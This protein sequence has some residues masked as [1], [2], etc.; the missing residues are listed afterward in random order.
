MKLKMLSLAALLAVFSILAVG[1]GNP[2]DE[3]IE[4]EL[5]AIF[6]EAMKELDNE[7]TLPENA[8]TKVEL[9]KTFEAEGFANT[10][11][12]Y[13]DN[14]G[15]P[16]DVYGFETAD[17]G[18]KFIALNVTV[19]NSG[20]EEAQASQLNYTLDFGGEENAEHSYYGT[21]APNIEHF[22]STDLGPGESYTGDFLFEVPAE[23]GPLN[24][25]LVFNSDP[26]DFKT[27]YQ[28]IL[29]PLQ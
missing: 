17:E 7:V 9:G 26:F 8:N 4:K 12:F 20:T 21:T 27:D 25:T 11:N 13:L 1:C 18:N 16:E 15:N 24:W 22:S 14:W 29:V 5:N 6:D 10:V 23:S 28:P 19:T 2:S 3:E